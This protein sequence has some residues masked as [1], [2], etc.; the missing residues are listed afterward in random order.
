MKN[1]LISSFVISIIS[2]ASSIARIPVQS[3]SGILTGLFS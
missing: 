3:L 2:F 1:K